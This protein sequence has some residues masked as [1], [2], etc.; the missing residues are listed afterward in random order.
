MLPIASSNG[1]ICA[2]Q[3]KGCTLSILPFTCL[4]YSPRAANQPW[5]PKLN[6]NG[7][8]C[9]ERHVLTLFWDGMYGTDRFRLN[10][11]QWVLDILWVTCQENETLHH[12]NVQKEGGRWRISCNVFYDKTD[13]TYIQQWV[14]YVTV[15]RRLITDDARK[16]SAKYIQ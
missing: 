13:T 9:T 15:G 4:N 1:G 2:S 16:K 5:G 3:T 12:S 10:R 6:V 11:A 14:K 7:H 8:Y